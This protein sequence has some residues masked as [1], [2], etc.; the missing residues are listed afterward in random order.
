MSELPPTTSAFRRRLPTRQIVGL[1]G[2]F[3]DGG[4][5]SI[6]GVKLIEAGL[7]HFLHHFAVMALPKDAPS[8]PVSRF[9][10]VRGSDYYVYADERGVFKT[11]FEL[12]E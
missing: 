12:G 11:L 6:A 7:R 9:I 2:E 8:P 10:E 5:V 1:G 4:G 3:E